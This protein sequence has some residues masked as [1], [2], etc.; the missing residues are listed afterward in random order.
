MSV[1]TATK[2]DST[3]PNA[4]VGRNVVFKGQIVSREDLTIHGEVEGTI[5]IGE[6]R[7]LIAPDGKVR[8]EV[9]VRELEVRG[10]IEGNIEATEKVYVRNGAKVVGNIHSA[11]IIIEDGAQIKGGIELLPPG[12]ESSIAQ[13]NSAIRELSDAV[14]TS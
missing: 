12:R 5:D 10:S 4:N 1:A 9:N 2:L 11:R 13:V 7:L 14:L 3:L 8:A 6:H